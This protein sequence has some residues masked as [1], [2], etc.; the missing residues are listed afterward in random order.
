MT[1]QIDALVRDIHDAHYRH[2]FKFSA[3]GWRLWE[4]LRREVGAS[5]LPHTP[6]FNEQLRREH[7]ARGSNMKASEV[8]GDMFNDRIKALLRDAKK[9]A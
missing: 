9:V 1:D 8:S 7:L 4:E 2:G 3:A 6:E 5:H